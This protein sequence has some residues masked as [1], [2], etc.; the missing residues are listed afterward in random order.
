MKLILFKEPEKLEKRCQLSDGAK[1]VNEQAFLLDISEMHVNTSQL[2]ITVIWL[3][4]SIIVGH[5]KE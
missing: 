2:I 1:Y 4:S 3:L 5:L